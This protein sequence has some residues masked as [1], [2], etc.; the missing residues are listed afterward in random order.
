MIGRS[1]VPGVTLAAVMLLHAAAAQP[2][3]ATSL[4]PLCRMSCPEE[5]TFGTCSAGKG[6]AIAAEGETPGQR[7]WIWVSGE[8]LASTD[9]PVD[10]RCGRL[11]SIAVDR[12]APTGMNGPIK[13]YVPRCMR[14]SGN[15]GDTVTALIFKSPDE[16]LGAYRP[17]IACAD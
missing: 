5:T 3:H 17:H 10:R 9:D 11:L 16:K 7:W 6:A 13:I 14:W 1:H 2:G 8:V 12:S 4:G 15:A